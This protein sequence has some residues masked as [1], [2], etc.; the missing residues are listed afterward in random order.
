MECDGNVNFRLRRR[1]SRRERCVGAACNYRGD[2]VGAYC[3]TTGN[4]H[5]PRLTLRR[6]GTW[7]GGC[8]IR[9]WTVV[10]VHRRCAAWTTSIRWYQNT[11]RRPVTRAYCSSLDR[12]FKIS[13]RRFDPLYNCVTT[14]WYSSSPL[15]RVVSSCYPV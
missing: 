8:G 10:T 7:R 11:S 13:I 12:S 2:G 5:A 1:S 6:L 9:L 3:V 4:R 14:V 15:T